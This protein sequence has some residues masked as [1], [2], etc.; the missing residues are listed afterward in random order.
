[1]RIYEEAESIKM[2]E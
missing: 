1:M 2:T